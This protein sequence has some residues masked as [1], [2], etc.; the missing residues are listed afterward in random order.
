MSAPAAG[1]LP[2]LANPVLVFDD[3]PA[4]TMEETLTEISL[5]LEAAGVVSDAEDLARRLLDRER[6]GCT[7]LGSGIA[8]PH[9]K[10]RG[11][12]DIVLAIA[13]CP[14]GVDFGAPDGILVTLILAILS[15]AE[16]PALHLQA[17]ARIS[18]LLRTPGV[19]DRLRA[20]RTA[21]GLLEA[22]RESEAGQAV[23]NR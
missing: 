4:G 3:V 2:G 12:A 10:V 5:R 20:A 15:P 22:L 8:I 9:C 23:P 17:L 1:A 18:R 11:L 7:G 6:L 14:S 16:A 21:D 13:P 19:A